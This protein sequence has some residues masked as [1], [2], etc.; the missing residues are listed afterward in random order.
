VPA[1][2]LSSLALLS[3]PEALDLTLAVAALAVF[4]V[5][6]PVVWG[7]AMAMATAPTMLAAP[8]PRVRADILACPCRR[9]NCRAEPDLGELFIGCSDPG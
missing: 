9:A 8:I 4:T 1:L 6:A 5:L 7:S 3:S 2:E